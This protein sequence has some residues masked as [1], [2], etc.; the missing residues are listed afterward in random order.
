MTWEVGS[1]LGTDSAVGTVCTGDLTPDC[2]ELGTLGV[3]VLDCIDIS[4]A[5]TEVE[6]G[7]FLGVDVCKLKD[8]SVGLGM[9]LVT[10]V[11]L[12]NTLDVELDLLDHP[13]GLQSEGGG[14]V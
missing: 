2:T 14:Y 11:C 6:L 5:L 13:K 7:V 8:C 10:G 3:T 12:D 4:N 9:C 1:K